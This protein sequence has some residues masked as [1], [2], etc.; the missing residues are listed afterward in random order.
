MHQDL[1]YLVFATQSGFIN[2]IEL[3]EIQSAWAV[4]PS[5]SLLDRLKDKIE[6]EEIDLLEKLVV[7]S[8]KKHD[9]NPEKTLSALENRDLVLKTLGGTMVQTPS[10]SVDA[11]SSERET[12]DIT[13]E[14]LGRYT[15]KGEAGRG[16]IGRVL[17]AFDEHVGRK[18][19]IKE[20]LGEESSGSEEKTPQSNSMNVRFLR[21][22]RVTGQLEHPS[23]VPV[24]EVGRKSDGTFYYTM[25]L[26]K[27]KN[28]RDAIK[29]AESFSQRLKLLTHFHD[30]C[31]AVAYAHSRGVIHRDIKPENVMIGEFGETVLLDWGL[32]KVK[33]EK[34]DGAGKLEKG[35]EL[36]KNLDADK[37][38]AGSALGTPAYM[39]PEQALGDIDDIDEQSD[40]YSLGAALYEILTGETPHT[41]MSAYDIIAKVVSNEII[42]VQQK[43]VKIP[44]E[45]GAIAE[46]ALQKKKGDRYLTSRDLAEEIEQYLSGEKVGAYEYSSWELM[47]RF[48]K[49]NKPAILSFIIVVIMLAL[50]MTIVST[51][52]IL[53]VVGVALVL[54]SFSYMKERKA[55]LEAKKM[56]EIAEKERAKA[57]VSR[58]NAEKNERETHYMLSQALMEKANQL[59]D[60]KDYLSAQIYA[61]GSLM[62]NPFNLYN[63]YFHNDLSTLDTPE[64]SVKLASAH[65]MLLQ[66][67][68]ENPVVASEMLMGHND[69]VYSIS[70]S[71]DG[72]LLASA[73]LDSTVLLWDPSTK[74]EVGEL[75]HESGVFF[76]SFSPDG[77]LLATA[78]MNNAVRLWNVESR[79]EIA[80]LRG[81]EDW[82]YCVGFSPDGQLLVSSSK[83]KTVRL[84]DVSTKKE[85]AVLS[86]HKDAIVA[87]RFSPDGSLLATASKD[88]TARLWNVLTQKE[89]AIFQGH[90]G[91]L[92][93]IVFSPDGQTLVTSSL[94]KTVRFW[95]VDTKKEISFI[96][97][98][99]ALISTTVSPDGKFVAMCG[100]NKILYIREVTTKKEIVALSLHGSSILYVKFSPNGSMLATSDGRGMVR[101]WSLSETNI[102]RKI[103]SG[104][105]GWVTSVAFSQDGRLLAS[106]GYDRTVRIW[107]VNT[108][109]ELV[110]LKGH[111]HTVNSVVFSPD[112]KLLVSTGQDGTVRLW[113]VGLQKEMAVILG[114]Q[115]F[116]YW[117]SFSPDG[118]MLATASE[119]SVKLWDV[120][121]RKE[122]GVISGHK[123]RIH[124]VVFS[125]DSLL[126]ASVSSD[127]TVRMWSVKTQ[128]Q[129]WVGFHEDIV[130]GVFFSPN[131]KIVASSGADRAISLWDVATG[132]LIRTIK[133]HTEWVNAI[134]FSP[135]GALLFSGSDDNTVKI[136][137]TT[138]GRCLQSIRIG[139]E[140][141]Q[142]VVS[143]D[144]KTFAINSDNNI[145]IFPID[146]DHWKKD[147]HELLKEAEK[148]AG[149]KL[150]GF[151][152]RPMTPE[153]WETYQ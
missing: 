75:V 136:W 110:V 90:E 59:Y 74:K 115:G 40:I 119:D 22:A 41:G 28:L 11:V 103:F 76:V 70:F 92:T 112:G 87:V 105:N 81:H 38:V 18:I 96:R 94:D 46:K 64:A 61:A 5:K 16:G 131:G 33:G 47:K 32:A 12:E 7:R 150:D 26:V 66:A 23:I 129:I 80:V 43:D 126:V 117:V 84:W 98:F 30:L 142:P 37:T 124:R 53:I 145:L 85:I 106:A 93:G 3:A 127:K 95:D 125:P 2:S 151:E 6:L 10:D 25:R 82:V 147:P 108:V 78:D 34:D 128:S 4:D 56:A 141:F 102:K 44:K 27:G 73:G 29:E 132:D 58:V 133:G 13:A 57:D 51:A 99:D 54:I 31:N 77:L 149:M 113:D 120:A 67:K 107:D 116:I 139:Y 88:K 49:K 101:V 97:V 15:L 135:E 69:A 21:E 39:P 100:I 148:A 146:L 86:G 104:H 48:V 83:D 122:I 50:T 130:T 35:I 63:P 140:G 137:E 68:V 60:K 153:E 138:T 65:S 144:G 152:L 55:K 143:P 8:L 17:I 79:K 1:L 20:L 109:Q 118:S 134:S 19:A 24:Y 9:N 14:S 52:M 72:S 114:N 121:S 62:H 91:W 89:V 36:L 111:E 123:K 71:P 45:L 42:P